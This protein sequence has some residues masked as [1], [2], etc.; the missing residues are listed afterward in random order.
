[1]TLC[2]RKGGGSAWGLCTDDLSVL[3]LDML[4]IVFRRSFGR[5]RTCKP[6]RERGITEGGIDPCAG[7]LAEAVENAVQNTAVTCGIPRTGVK[8]LSPLH[9]NRVGDKLAP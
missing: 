2:D 5:Q 8:P 3:A 9:G 1:M 4:Q 7:A 6:M